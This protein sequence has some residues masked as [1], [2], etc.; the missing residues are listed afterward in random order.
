MKNCKT[1]ILIILVLLLIFADSCKNVEKES[2]IT[3]DRSGNFL[4]GWSVADITPD[5]PVLLRGQYHARVSEGVMDPVTATVLAMESGNGASSEKA[6]MV[7]C[8]LV[9]IYDGMHDGSENNLRDNVRKL[10]VESVPEL[11]PERIFLHATHTHTAPYVSGD[12]D[13]NRYGVELDAMSPAECCD[14]ISKRIAKAGVEAWK[15]RKPGGISY[16]LGYAVVARNRIQALLSGKSVKG[17]STNRPDF[18]HVEGYEDHTIN[19]LYTWDNEKNLTGVVINIATDP[20][21]TGGEF[22]I[23]AD[24]W[25]EIRLEVRKRL[26]E[27]VFVYPQ[28]AAAG[29]QGTV[30]LVGGAAEFRMQE[31]MYPVTDESIEERLRTPMSR[32]K[33]IANH[34]ADA[35]TDVYPYM[36]DYI[37]WDPEFAHRMEVVDLTRRKI[38]SEEVDNALKES[39][40]FKEKFEQLKAEFDANPGLK[41]EPRWYRD[42]TRIHTQMMRGQNVKERYEMEQQEPKMP[43][44]VH[45]VRIGDIALATNPFELYLDFGMR[46]KAR[47]PAI[48]TFVI[49]LAGDGTYVPTERSAAG[50]AYGA[51]PASNLVGPEGGQELVEKTLEMINELFET[52]K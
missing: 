33:R 36:G 34:I 18:S 31:I 43:V 23:S 25:H 39:E 45:V 28:C 14:Y 8:D 16:G 41:K 22:S 12:A 10:I 7:S 26:G 40:E 21:S 17:G 42:I 44:E 46:M 52:N 30:I 37:D 47:S 35:V 29:D 2:D 51:V 5:E 6:I 11:N 13:A 49:Q 32:R 48:Q 15:N 50:G 27:D 3:D 20:Q 24:F 9:A 1:C 19:L 38:S 4:I